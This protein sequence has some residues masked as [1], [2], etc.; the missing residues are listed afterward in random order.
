MGRL[1]ALRVASKVHL[2]IRIVVRVWER[3]F[4]PTTSN[5]GPYAEYGIWAA[6]NDF[7]AS[8][9]LPQS[10]GEQ[11]DLS[12]R[13]GYVI[14]YDPVFEDVIPKRMTLTTLD[15]RGQI[16]EENVPIR[17]SNRVGHRRYMIL[18]TG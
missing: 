9:A 15:D 13:A 8:S 14:R 4:I 2:N 6:L 18:E 16:V 12:L 7:A 11:F 5:R 3:D 17:R 1:S 10:I